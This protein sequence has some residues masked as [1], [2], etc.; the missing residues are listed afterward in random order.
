M[1]VRYTRQTLADPG[2]IPPRRYFELKKDFIQIG[3]SLTYFRGTL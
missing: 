3:I 1:I 2:H